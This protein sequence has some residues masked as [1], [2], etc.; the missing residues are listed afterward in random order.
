M[1]SCPCKM[2]KFFIEPDAVKENVISIKGSDAIHMTRSLRLK[3]GEP[4]SIVSKDGIEYKTV[5]SGINNNEVTLDILEKG[6][7]ITEPPVKVSL[8][9]G[10]PKGDKM[11]EVVQKCIETGVFEITPVI[12][13]RTVVRINT[14]QEGIKKAQKWQ[15]TSREAAKQCG[16]GIIPQVCPPVSFKKAVDI[17]K[18]ENFDVCIMPYEMESEK[19]LKDLLKFL[20]K[21]CKIAVVIGP[22]G[23][24]SE[25]EVKL[26]RDYGIHTITL[27]P[28]ILRTETAG[29]VMLSIIMYEL[30]DIG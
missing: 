2:P 3:P 25:N 12:T 11:D 22:E 14:E 21:S 7:A 26:A 18:N 15:K 10:V 5:F 28:R 23:G 29:A 24:F 19:R 17:I 6:I 27:G 4:V 20:L 16:R 13:D 1:D 9:Q 8:F 30:G